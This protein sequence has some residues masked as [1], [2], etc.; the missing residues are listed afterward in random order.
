ME[1]KNVFN[2]TQIEE[3]TG[4]KCVFLEF[5]TPAPS[6]SIVVAQKIQLEMEEN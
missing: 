2:I 1:R 5:V 6:L 4:R 3:K